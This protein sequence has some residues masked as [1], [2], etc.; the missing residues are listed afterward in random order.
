MQKSKHNLV[1]RA[2]ERDVIKLVDATRV[3]DAEIEI[4]LVHKDGFIVLAVGEPTDSKRFNWHQWSYRK[5]EISNILIQNVLGYNYNTYL[6][7]NSFKSPKKTL[8]NLY[9]LNALWSDIDYYKVTKYKNKSY[10]EMINIISKNKLIKK[11]PPSMWIYSGNG[12]YPLWLIEDAHAEACLPL[13]NKLMEIINEELEKYGADW[14][15]AEAS[16]VLRLAGSN[17]IKTNT[18]AKIVKDVFNFNP[19][20]YT[21]SELSELIL[22]KLDYSKEEWTAIKSKKRKSKKDKEACKIHSLFNVHSLNYARMQDIQ[23]LIEIRNGKCEGTRELMIFLYRYWANCF[24]KDD[25]KALIEIYELNS[26]FIEPLEESEVIYATKNAAEAAALWES[27]LNEYLTLESKPSVKKFFEKTGAYIYSNKR[28]IELLNIEQEEM[29]YLYTIFNTK[30]KN[31]R[32]KDYRNEWKRNS[33]KNENGLNSRE[34]AKINNILIV[35]NLIEQGFKNKDIVEKTGL[36]KGTVSK[37]SKEYL[38]K[39]EYYNE[40]NL[41]SEEAVTPVLSRVTDNELSILVI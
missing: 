24:Y 12:I 5:A 21:L 35:G 15:S 1:K 16:H 37:Y 39:K 31:R 23:K 9:S 13:W 19:K 27:K 26:M 17:N 28:L 3:E 4:D 14:A 36:A 32:N 40:F 18:H 2:K 8:S 22:P 30:E 11:I 29:R 7:L 33:R 10:E 38:E 41:I 6:S 25:E 20:R 34:Q